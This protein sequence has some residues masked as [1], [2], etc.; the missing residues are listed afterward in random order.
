MDTIP[1]LN[2]RRYSSDNPSEEIPPDQPWTSTG[3][4]GPTLRIEFNEPTKINQL[5][6]ITTTGYSS[7]VIVGV[8]FKSEPLPI[9][10]MLFG[11]QQVYVQ[12]GTRL[13]I[14]QDP[15]IRNV[16]SIHLT[17][18]YSSSQTIKIYGCV[19]KGVCSSVF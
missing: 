13:D 6:F 19:E 15:E 4:E 11:G 2:V 18:I 16:R 17:F 5:E 12:F 1:N 9:D 3:Q 8:S 14:P 7:K 10:Q